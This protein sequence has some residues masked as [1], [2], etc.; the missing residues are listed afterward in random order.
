[1]GLGAEKVIFTERDYSQ[2]IA[3]VIKGIVCLQGICERGPVND[4][5]KIGSWPEF[6]RI[7]GNMLAGV[8]FPLVC[9]RLLDRGGVIWVNRLEHYSDV[10]D[11]TTITAETATTGN[12][13]DRGLG[14]EAQSTI[15]IDA[16]NP[17]IWG[18]SVSVT[19]EDG[20]LDPDNEFN[21]L[22][23]YSG[24]SN[25]DE[26]FENVSMDSTAKN[27]FA[28]KINNKS[29]LIMV[30]D[31]ESST[32]APGNR[33]ATGEYTLT[34]GTDTYDDIVAAD[35][36]GDESAFTGFYAFADVDDSMYLSTPGVTDVTVIAAGLTYCEAR[37]DMIYFFEVPEDLEPQ[38]A[39]NYRIGQDPYTHTAF[40]S[41]YGAIFFG[42]PLVYNPLLDV[43]Q[44]ISNQGDVLGVH[45]RNDHDAKEWFAAAGI[46]RGGIPNVLGLDFNCGTR[47]R[48]SLLDHLAENQVNPLV[49]FPKE[50]MKLWGNAT[51][52]RQTSVLQ[53]LHVRKLLVFMRKLL[54][55]IARYTLFEPNDPITWRL[56]HRRI[57]PWLRELKAQRAFYD[58]K[59]E[60][61]Q[62][63]NTIEDA[64]VNTL[65]GIERGEYRVR[66]F[67]KPTKVVK[68]LLLDVIL[69]STTARFEEV[70]EDITF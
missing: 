59:Y 31:L 9:K 43:N 18:N 4:P 30:E 13:D 27:Y 47:A 53:D 68:W 36:I 28:N 66:I 1:M 5:Q 24:Q 64:E 39:V 52:S 60:G 20:T 32:T 8:E 42:R 17:G 35:Y 70:F 50:G 19:I 48:Q 51:V 21:V 41:S 65:A 67:V 29:N 46:N 37:E 6:Q 54:I 22:V 56:M 2:Y 12:I 26:Y 23:S 16:T 15:K 38:N 3:Q 7:Y 25:M 14:T 44:Y 34:G 11:V 45:V 63:A 61:D 10:S 69:T 62:S 57:D 55:P 33:P 58:Y 40:D 49:I